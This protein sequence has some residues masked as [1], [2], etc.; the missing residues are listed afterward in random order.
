MREERD[1]HTETQM[2]VCTHTCTRENAG[3]RDWSDVSTSLG[4][5]RIASNHQELG[6]LIQILIQNLQKEPTLQQ[7][8]FRLLVFRTVRE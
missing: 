3:G 1:L 2:G 5:P 8:D 6:G 4:M 7:L